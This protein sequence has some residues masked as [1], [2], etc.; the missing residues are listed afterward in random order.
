MLDWVA[1][2]NYSSLHKWKDTLN[3][4]T[5][6]LPENE[7]NCSNKEPQTEYLLLHNRLFRLLIWIFPESSE[8]SFMFLMV[9]FVRVG[10][11]QSEGRWLNTCIPGLVIGRY[12]TFHEL[13]GGENLFCLTS[14]WA[15]A[16]SIL[17][18]TPLNIFVLYQEP[19]NLYIW[20]IMLHTIH[21]VN[22]VTL[23]TLTIRQVCWVWQSIITTSHIQSL[24]F[25]NNFTI[26]STYQLFEEFHVLD[27]YN[28]NINHPKTSQSI[29]I[30]HFRIFFSL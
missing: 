7:R 23:T 24:C 27:F 18:R 11:S 2:D 12:W 29:T 26:I 10:S 1:A 20:Y 15:T 22:T 4:Q 9:R 8:W 28:T 6:D 17:V 13:S 3:P 19:S 5:V 16:P 25:Q 30:Q 21:I 14:P